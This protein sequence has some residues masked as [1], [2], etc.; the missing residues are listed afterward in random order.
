MV[1][2]VHILQR[3]EIKIFDI[4]C[5]RLLYILFVSLRLLFYMFSHVVEPF[6]L[7]CS[8]QTYWFIVITLKTTFW[9]DNEEMLV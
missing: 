8:G 3:K 5:C 1:D 7:F 4:L 6:S 2:N 9:L